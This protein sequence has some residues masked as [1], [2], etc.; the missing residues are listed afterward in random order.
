MNDPL[1]GS[2]N[3]ILN[4]GKK[5]SF[6]PTSPMPLTETSIYGILTLCHCAKIELEILV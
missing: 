2:V 3:H 6:Y 4:I 1:S 5:V